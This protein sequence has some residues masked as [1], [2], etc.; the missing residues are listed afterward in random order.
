MHEND[1]PD[2]SEVFKNFDHIDSYSLAK[3]NAIKRRA[4][5]LVHEN[6]NTL[7]YSINT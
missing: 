5:K 6:I 2:V 7:L 3:K 1:S 4:S